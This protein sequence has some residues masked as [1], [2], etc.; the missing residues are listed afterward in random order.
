M[1]VVEREHTAVGLLVDGV[2]EVLYLASDEIDP[3][4]EVGGGAEQW[5]QGVATVGDR[6]ILLLDLDR[7][8]G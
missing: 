2:S 8:L 3:P 7:T 4:S 5:I 6:L 1:V